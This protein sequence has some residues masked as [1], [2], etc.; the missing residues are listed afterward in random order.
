[1]R[2]QAQNNNP[3]QMWPPYLNKLKH[4]DS[5]TKL[6]K[7]NCEVKHCVEDGGAASLLGLDKETYL[8]DEM[9]AIA[10]EWKDKGGVI[11]G[12]SIWS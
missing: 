8:W 9:N 7:D 1:M 10:E 6:V 11:R 5:A 2:M 4:D 3:S 12:K